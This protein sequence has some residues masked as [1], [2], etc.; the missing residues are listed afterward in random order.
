[1][2]DL[3]HDKEILK[4]IDEIFDDIW[5]G[6]INKFEVAEYSNC[7]MKQ[8]V[9]VLSDFQHG[10]F[11]RISELPK[12]SQMTSNDDVRRDTLRLFL[13]AAN[14]DDFPL[15]IDML[16]ESSE[17]DVVDFCY[18]AESSLSL[19]T[20]PYLL[21]LFEV[22]E[23]T[24]IGEQ[25]CQTVGYIINYMPA[26][27]GDCS[28]EELETVCT[29]FLKEHDPN[30]YYY[31]G[32]KFFVGDLTK[33]LINEMMLCKSGAKPYFSNQLPS[34]LSVVTGIKC[35]IQYGVEISDMVAEKVMRYVKVLSTKKWIPG[36]KYFYGNPI[37]HK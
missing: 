8:L 27:D 24:D 20:I 17:N 9:D 25:V 23:G 10:N 29:Q 1:M 7:E 2:W 36:C 13:S 21:A 19:Q 37:K 22:W 4:M 31:A 14:H 28:M 3:E 16:D 18:F 34:I 11:D 32:K 26:Q 15:L 5:F 35:P 6:K 30:E 12:I 33:D